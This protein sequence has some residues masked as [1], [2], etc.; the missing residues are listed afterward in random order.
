MFM[1]TSN[2]PIEVYRLFLAIHD[3]QQSPDDKHIGR[4]QLPAD[5]VADQST[6]DARWRDT[7]SSIPTSIT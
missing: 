2:D 1:Y 5:A 4:V 3:I 7:I 6:L